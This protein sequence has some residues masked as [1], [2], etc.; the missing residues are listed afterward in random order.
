VVV[1]GKYIEKGDFDQKWEDVRRKLLWV[2]GLSAIYQMP[3][4][5]KDTQAIRLMI[6]IT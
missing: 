6:T 5:V 1:F 3:F 4:P 2:G